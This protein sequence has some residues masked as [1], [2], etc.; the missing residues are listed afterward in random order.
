MYCIVVGF[1]GRAGAGKDRAGRLAVEWA[2]KVGRAPER[3]S[4]GAAI[5]R[6]AR[7]GF[8]WNGQKDRR[9]RRLLQHVG[10][11]G[12]AYS[13]AMWL[14][15]FYARL[16]QLRAVRTPWALIVTD[17]R[18]RREA[19]AIREVGGRVIRIYGRAE[20]LT[21]EAA[22]HNTEKPLSDEL[23]DESINNSGTL[24]ELKEQTWTTMD[25]LFP[26]TP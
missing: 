17:V 20:P 5:K 12:R 26:R 25:R 4:F 24:Q 15:P 23:I 21:V 1:A 2:L 22:A 13:P 6:A 7:V 9:G 11:T 14:R 19:E 16:I 10:D 18:R 3:F 8:G